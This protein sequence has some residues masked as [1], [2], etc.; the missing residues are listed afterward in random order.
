M[1][2]YDN[3]LLLRPEGSQSNCR[4]M[5]LKRNPPV[6]NKT[7]SLYCVFADKSLTGQEN[8]NFTKLK[9]RSNNFY[10]TK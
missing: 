7:K 3:Q 10:I 2:N 1:R 5:R 6:T 8:T 9:A 4:L